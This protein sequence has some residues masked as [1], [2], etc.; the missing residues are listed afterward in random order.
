M[1][2]ARTLTNRL[3]LASF[4]V[5]GACFVASGMLSDPLAVGAPSPVV[6]SIMW[7][8]MLNDA[9]CGVVESSPVEF[10]AGGDSGGRGR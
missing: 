7:S 5:A 10:N 3:V 6:A 4:S 2:H 9:P 1:T 8:K